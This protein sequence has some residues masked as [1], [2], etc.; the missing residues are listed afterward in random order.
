MNILL[1]ILIV[2]LIAIVSYYLILKLINNNFSIDK[3]L[4]LKE[5]ILKAPNCTHAGLGDRIGEYILY[6]TLGKILKCKV[7]CYWSRDTPLFTLGARPND[8]PENINDYIKF[9]DNIILVSKQQWKNYKYKNICPYRYNWDNYNV[10]DE[11]IPEIQ[12]I[13]LKLN[14]I[15][16]F[17][18][19]L[20]IYKSC[21]KEFE[22]KKQLPKIDNN[23]TGIHIRRGDKL[24]GKWDKLNNKYNE[25]YYDDKLL[26]VF[27]KLKVHRYILC[28]E[29]NNPIKYI[30]PIKLCLSHDKKIKTLEEFFIL[31][32]VNRIIQSVPGDNYYGGWTSFSY[33]AS[34]IGDS[35]LYSCSLP[36]TRLYKLQD[37]NNG[38]QLYN[39]IKYSDL[40]K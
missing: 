37:K 31:T 1:F 22:Y 13:K 12:Y 25:K 18:N 4:I 38:K 3:L 5:P 16:S 39:I 11:L 23:L 40:I 34:R 7:V 8:Y 9:P 32:K 10:G 30:K 21:A 27:D 19:Y 2:I 28:T 33:I 36:G 14:N 20:T 6:S 15:I 26:N 35:V 24:N 29:S 17:N